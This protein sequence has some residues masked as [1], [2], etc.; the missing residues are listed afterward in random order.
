MRE[1]ARQRAKLRMWAATPVSLAL[2]GLPVVLDIAFPLWIAECMLWGLI[3][4]GLAA[5][6]AWRG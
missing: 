1:V 3:V 6:W 4:G 2:M 5:Q